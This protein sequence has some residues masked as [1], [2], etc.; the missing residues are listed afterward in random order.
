[1]K[2]FTYQD[3]ARRGRLERLDYT[4]AGGARKHA[5]VYLPYGYGSDPA[6][7]YDVLYLMHGGGG[8]PEH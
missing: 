8:N 7:R 3:E 4:G 5:L 6:R 1:M 2:E